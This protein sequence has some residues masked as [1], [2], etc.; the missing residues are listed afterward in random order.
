VTEP[1]LS[2]HDPDERPVRTRR[3][4]ELALVPAEPAQLIPEP[5]S[6]AVLQPPPPVDPSRRRSFVGQLWAELALVGR[7][8]TDP[9]YRVSRTAQFAVPAIFVLFAANYLLFNVW[10]PVVPFV[11]P[12]AER[13]GCVVLAI[14]LYKVMTRELGRYREVL[15]Y[16]ARFGTHG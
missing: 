8:Y 3:T 1:A 4:T 14:T 13:L 10:F 6:G 7:M 9:R 11:T 16:L 2:E 5:P 15:D 12:I